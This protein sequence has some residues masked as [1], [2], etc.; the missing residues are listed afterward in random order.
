VFGLMLGAGLG[1]H[2]VALLVST[3]LGTALLLAGAALALTG[4]VWVE[5][6]ADEVQA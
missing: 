1:G 4:T 3:P 6:L 5:R 2:P